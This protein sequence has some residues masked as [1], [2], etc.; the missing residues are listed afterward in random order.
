[1]HWPNGVVYYE[2]DRSFDDAERRLIL[3]A[4]AH[5]S[6]HSCVRYALEILISN[7]WMPLNCRFEARNGQDAYVQIWPGT[8][9]CYAT[10]GYRNEMREIGLQMP[11]CNS[12]YVRPQTF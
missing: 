6:N 1:M 7:Q 5:I 12:S 11:T 2:V 9:G 10:P 4:M 8:G 3:Q